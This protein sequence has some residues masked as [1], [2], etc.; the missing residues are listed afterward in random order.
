[1]LHHDGITNIDALR[2]MHG[3]LQPMLAECD[4]IDW[5][6]AG[7]ESGKDARPMHPDWARSLRDQCAAAGVPFL[8]K[9]WGEWAPGEIYVEGDRGGL[10]RFPD[11]GAETFPGKPTHWWGETHAF[12]PGPI[13][14]AVGKKRAGRLLDGVLHDG[15]PGGKAA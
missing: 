4:K 11:H 10:A 3:V 5:I 1:M 15:F 8:F 12:N 7:G 2:G 14:V 9:Q 13:S 6:V